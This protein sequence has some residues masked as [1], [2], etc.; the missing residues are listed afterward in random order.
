MAPSV[1][2]PMSKPLHFPRGRY[3]NK[4]TIPQIT[5]LS[6]ALLQTHLHPLQHLLRRHNARPFPD[7]LARQRATRDNPN[8]RG[9]REARE[10]EARFPALRAERREDGEL[11]ETGA[12]GE[13]GAG[14]GQEVGRAGCG[15]AA[16]GCEEGGCGG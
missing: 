9:A 16:K 1:S 5:N 3:R 6:S 7:P 12:G 11:V 15:D 8:H 4:Q 2:H 14:A 10:Q 13:V